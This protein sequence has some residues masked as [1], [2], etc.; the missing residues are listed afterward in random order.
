M[1][2]ISA[3]PF[4]NPEVAAGYEM[5]YQ[6]IGCRADRQEK[7]LLKWLLA[8][9]PDTRSILE[10]GCGT[11]HFTRWLSDQGLNAVG[12]DSSRIML[13]E[14]KSMESPFCLQGI[15]QRLPFSSKSFDLVFMIT[16][17][18]FLSKPMQSLVEALRVARQGLI[19]G[20]LNAES[21]VG[22]RYKR[23]GGPIWESA[24]FYT[25]SGLKQMIREVAGEKARIVWRTTLW[26]SWPCAV[27]LP[28]GGFIGMAVKI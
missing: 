2:K 16:T 7:A 10:V 13:E 19:L 5:W 20:V 22:R 24:Q 25:P 28:W 26:P 1:G 15:A 12:L 4:T 17:L 23:A 18:E 8:G 9:F 6:T 27:P 11:G 21:Y 14:A 3:N